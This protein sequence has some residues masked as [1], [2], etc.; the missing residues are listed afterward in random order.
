MTTRSNAIPESFF[1]VFSASGVIVAV[2]AE[3]SA[4]RSPLSPALDRVGDGRSESPRRCERIAEATLTSLD[5]F[6]PALPCCCR[7]VCRRFKW[8][9]ASTA[10]TAFRTFCIAV[11]LRC[12][13]IVLRQTPRI[14]SSCSSGRLAS[15]GCFS[16]SL[17]VIRSDAGQ[18]HRQ[19]NSLAVSE[20]SPQYCGSNSTFISM[21]CWKSVG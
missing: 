9:T 10:V 3:K 7:R 20:M 13:P 19:I 6:S 14:A 21:I 4:S 5:S 18:R 17:A 15:Q 8:F 12:A 16:A 2:E 1:G 11:K